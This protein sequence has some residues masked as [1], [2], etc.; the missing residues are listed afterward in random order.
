MLPG[1]RRREHASRTRE[2]TGILSTKDADEELAR[3]FLA[4]VLGVPVTMHDRRAGHST[5]DLEIRYPDGRRGAAEVISTWTKKQAAQLG[6]V[7]RYGYT[8]DRQLRNTWVVRVPPQTVISR[9]L[10]ALPQFLAELERAGVTD[11]SPNRYYG[12][13]M[14]ERLRRLHISSGLADP[15][16][17]GRQPGFYVYPEATGAWVG[18]GEEIR[19]FCESFLSDAAQADVLRKLAGSGADE[20]HAVVVATQG[21]LGLHTAV[22]IRLTPSQ[23]PDLDGCIDW[24]WVIASQN[25]PVRG[26]HWTS[27]YGWA[28]AVLAAA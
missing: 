4:A 18:D 1:R 27:Q 8:P 5:Y 9:V 7:H 2:G 3:L 21:Q 19:L 28:T 16:T 13:A 11:L 24:L 15:P 17:I 22:D 20:R 25:L 10:P 14:H 26:C 12:P 6:A 23:A